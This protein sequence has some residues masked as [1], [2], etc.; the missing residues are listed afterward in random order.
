VTRPLVIPSLSTEY[1]R[2]RVSAIGSGEPVNPTTVPV[3]MAF[4][5]DGVEPGSSD[6]NAGIWDTDATTDP[7]TYYALCLIGP[8]GVVLGDGQYRVWTRVEDTP[9]NAA[10]PAGRLVVT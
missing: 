6:W 9:E 1:I 7:P 8:G 3:S 5:E 4:M 2:V 10:R